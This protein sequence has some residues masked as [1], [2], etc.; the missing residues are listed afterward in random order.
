MRILFLIL[1]FITQQISSQDY[2]KLKE[3]NVYFILFDSE[4][5][6]TLCEDWKELYET[7]YYVYTFFTSKKEEFIY[8]FIYSAF[9]FSVNKKK[10]VVFKVDESFLEKNKDIIITREFM[11]QIGQDD[12]VTLFYNASS[13]FL[14]N[15][16]ENRNG[17][18]IIREVQ[19]DYES[20]AHDYYGEEFIEDGE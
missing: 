20:N 18:I 15:T 6:F 19:L 2:K 9:D 5:E 16:A 13:I 4:S 8:K 1:I 3:E 10:K 11:E 12:M 17:K 7:E 14:I